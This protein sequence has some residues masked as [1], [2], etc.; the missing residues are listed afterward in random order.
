M[1]IELLY[2]HWILL[3]IILMISEIFLASFFV[4]WFGTAAVVTG[5]LVF[6]MPTLTPALQ[7]FIWGILSTLS[8][9][10]WFKY[11]KP[12]AIDKF[13]AGLSKDSFAGEVGQVLK[14]P[15]GKERGKLRFP[16]PVS[17]NDEWL[18]VSSDKL[19]AGDRVHVT[20]LSGSALIV[21]KS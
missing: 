20:G 4:I 6:F 17:G 11:L 1:N 19:T 3:G 12:Q 8:A 9:L 15:E 13:N 2:W 18:I 5:L 16:A 14:A 7:V 21:E 10:I